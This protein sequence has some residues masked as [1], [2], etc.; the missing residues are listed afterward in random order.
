MV[1]KITPVI[2][3]TRTKTEEYE[4]CPHCQEEIKEK[5]IYVDEENYVYHRSC[6]DKGPIDQIKP[7]SKDELEKR[8]GWGKP[9]L[10]VASEEKS[11]QSKYDPKELEMGI[12]IEKEHK[13]LYDIFKS[14]FD[15]H[16]IEMPI[17]EKEMFKTIAKS[18][19][20]EF[21]NYYE[22]LNKMEEKLKNKLEANS[23]YPNL[24][25]GTSIHFSK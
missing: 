11:D 2:K 16:N 24:N 21:S 25:T 3:K 13:D 15:K 6:M 1:K 9:E 22:E 7:L 17:S 10:K 5:S 20:R 19:L 14:F 8:L 12:E 18:H 23:V 4:V